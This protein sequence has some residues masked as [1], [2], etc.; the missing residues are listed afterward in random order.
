MAGVAG[1]IDVFEVIVAVGNAVGLDDDDLN[2][3]GV[4]PVAGAGGGSIPLG[5]D[6]LGADLAIA[7]ALNCSPL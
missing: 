7:V 3:L 2:I 4:A 5:V 1:G 6:P